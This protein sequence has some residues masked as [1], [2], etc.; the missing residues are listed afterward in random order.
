MNEDHLHRTQIAVHGILQAAII[1]QQITVCD[2]I[3]IL[4][5]EKAT[6]IAA[7]PKMVTARDRVKQAREDLR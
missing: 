3:A 2:G 4:E 5:M 7:I 6:L 1:H